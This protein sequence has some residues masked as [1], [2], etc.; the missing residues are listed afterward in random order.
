[1]NVLIADDD[2]ITREG[3][4]ENI[5]WS[6]MN[7]TVTAT[8][9]N[10]KEALQL[11]ADNDIDILITD[12]RMPYMTGFELVNAANGKGRYP[13]TIII[14][15]YDDYEYLQQAIKL[16]IILGYIFKPIQLELL[17][18]LLLEAIEFRKDWLEKN[19]VLE[20]TSSDLNQYSYKNVMINL[21]NIEAIYSSLISNDTEKACFLLNESWQQTIDSSCSLN[22]SKRYAWELVISLMQMLTKDGINTQ[23]IIMG[24][25]PLS[26]ISSLSR[27]QEVY[28]FIA[29]LLDNICIYIAG[30]QKYSDPKFT[31]VQKALETRFDDP[32]LTLLQ[33]ASELNVSANYLG[34][35][36]KKERGESFNSELT[37]IR[38]AKAKQL[39]I[40]SNLKV[41]DI[42][43]KCGFSDS[44]Y[45]ALTF[46]K[47][48]GM[49]PSDYR[50]RF[51]HDNDDL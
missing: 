44:K 3:I 26:I 8:A 48:T 32:E 45:F 1:M 15:G 16:H 34:T 2:R 39:L 47:I 46:R 11:L 14:S 13:A 23:D 9:R 35:I 4:L 7:L 36:Y 5:D 33:I 20:M 31:Y 22:F 41:Y 29:D 50:A 40:T 24:A 43:Q 19:V 18:G 21:K 28:D 30:R 10:G 51:Y 27:K 37:N 6:S 25:D 17:N 38:I 12:I 42:S 49:T